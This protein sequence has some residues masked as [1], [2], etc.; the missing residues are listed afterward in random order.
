VVLA[1]VTV[2]SKELF[3]SGLFAGLKISAGFSILR[4]TLEEGGWPGGAEG[5]GT[6]QNIEVPERD[7]ALCM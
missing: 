2:F 5:E 7:R 6:I 3:S 1:G 4:L